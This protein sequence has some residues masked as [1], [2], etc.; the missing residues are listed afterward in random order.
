MSRISAISI[1]CGSPRLTAVTLLLL[2]AD[3]QP[4]QAGDYFDPAA[5]EITDPLQKAADLR[6]FAR[7]GGQ[8]PGNWELQVLVN[9][10]QVGRQAITVIEEAGQLRP[11]LSTT[12]LAAWGVNVQAFAG[13]SRQQTVSDIGRYIPDASSQLDFSQQRLIL[14]IPQAAMCGQQRDY[15]DPASWDDGVAAAFSDYSLTGSHSRNDSGSDRASY[16]NLRNGVN[17][18][19]WRLRNYADFRQD[20]RSHWHSRASWLQRDIKSWRSQLRMGDTFTAGELF[21]SVQFRG[22]E[23]ASEEEMLPDS[24]RGFAPAI[25]GMAYSNARVTVAQHGDVIYE[26]WVTPGEFLLS[27][28][29]PTSQSGDLEVTIKESDGAERKFIQPYSASARM[30][31]AGRVR[32]SLSAGQYTPELAQGAAQPFTQSTL[33]YGLPANLT[34]YG[35]TQLAADYQA[36]ALGAVKGL[37]ALGSL[38]SDL[39]LADSRTPD[40]RTRT[41][42]SLRVQYQKEVASSRTSVNLLGY[43]NSRGYYAFSEASLLHAHSVRVD[44]TRSRIEVS[45]SQALGDTSS[46]TVSTWSQ[47]YWH[48][49]NRDMTLHL[50]FYNNTRGLSWG[51]GCYYTKSPQQSRADRSMSLNLSLPLG[52]WLT[53]GGVSYSTTAGN[54]GYTSQQVSLYGRLAERPDLNY[55]LQ[56]GSGNKHQGISSSLALDYQGGYGSRQLGWRQDKNRDQLTW[57][58]SGSVVAHPHGIT[59][60]QITG[61]SFAIVRAPGAADVAIE[62]GS[63]IRTDGRGYAIVPTLTSWRK[64]YITLDSESMMDDV[65]VERQ[66][67]TVIPAGGAVVMANYQTRIGNR[68]LFTLRNAEGPL[69]FGAT[70]QLASAADDSPIDGLVAERGQV[71]L[72][73]M[74]ERGTLVAVWN[75]GQTRH[76][77]HMNYTIPMDQRQSAV[78]I[79][80]GHCV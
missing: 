7:Q 60:G 13:L 41:G 4:A 72:S 76:R 79:V 15:I 3:L 37:G 18:G 23:L 42:H 58:A 80:A 67:Q 11:V 52:Q 35:G 10:Q 70:V 31:R 49:R 62:N 21:D 29:Y 6:Y 48:S 53:G 30:L 24:M 63:N 28:L 51:L 46:L 43:R 33:F 1:S 22:I 73:G 74:P 64:N 26:T 14:S 17:L 5:L 77:C 8:L 20:S 69:P 32:Y 40:N 54:S 39:V 38:G 57:S 25:R 75:S 55:S 47:Q 27:D 61:D 12:R 36:Y 9:Q 34:L 19:V 78:K 2:F 71:Y 68:V 65:D 16:L 44:N 66:G 56:Q 59:F 45:I 50:G